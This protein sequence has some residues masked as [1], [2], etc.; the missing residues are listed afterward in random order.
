VTQASLSFV[1]R[2]GAAFNQVVGGLADKTP[3]LAAAIL[4]L[5]I[6]WL[7]G[8]LTF[9]AT[10]RVLSKRSTAAHVDV[11]V[12]R[13]ARSCVIALGVVVALGIVGVNLTALVASLGLVGITLGFALRDVLANSVSGVLLLLQRP[14]GIGDSVGVAGVEGVVEDIRV[15]DTVLRMADGRRAYIPNTTVFN[16]VVVNSSHSAVRRFEVAVAVPAGQDLLDAV[17]RVRNAIAA[18][19]G[20]LKEPAADASLLV[21]GTSRARIVAHGW[22]DTGTTGLDV[23]RSAALFAASAAVSGN[24]AETC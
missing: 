3:S 13:F 11:I 19:A 20:V 5:V 15:R 10:R 18:G 16:E 24:G 4:V 9:A 12:A 1:G 14:F 8:R 21:V 23:A 17:E 7:V 2:I 6:T 22:V